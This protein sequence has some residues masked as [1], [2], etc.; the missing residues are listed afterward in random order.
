MTTLA[1]ATGRT[2]VS[3]RPLLLAGAAAAPIFTVVA[4]AQTFTREAYDL[5]RHPVSM[6]ANGDLGWIQT[7]SFLT[8]GA[9]TVA[10]AVGAR[11]VLRGGKAGTWGPILLAVIGLGMLIAGVFRMDAADG[12]PIGTPAGVPT[13]M[14]SEAM[15][16]NLGGSLSFF[17]MIALCFVLARR[18]TVRGERAWA[19]GGRVCG[20][21]FALGLGWAFSGGTAGAL[22]LFLGVVIAWGWIA[23][24]LVRLVRPAN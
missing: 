5:T 12:F 23:A 22:T 14:S 2:T 24:S 7:M 8:T 21:L 9:L 10:G 16:H 1:H 13:T 17:S 20:V 19:V 6:L 18:F 3:T 11:R 4:L 15:L